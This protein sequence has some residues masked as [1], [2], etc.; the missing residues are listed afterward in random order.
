MPSGYFNPPCFLWVVIA[1]CF[2]ALV[3]AG[4]Q[5]PLA[6]LGTCTSAEDCSLNGDCES[7]VC[8][9]DNFWSGS[10]ACDVL[11]LLP[12][13]H[14]EGYRNSSGVSSWGGMSIKNPRTG[15]WE[16]FAAEMVNHCPLAA[17]KDNSRI[18]RGVSLRGPAGP[19]VIEQEVSAPFSHNPKILRATDGTY[20]LFS[21]GSGL[22]TTAPQTCPAAAD[23]NASQGAARLLSARGGQVPY[24]G[25]CGDGCGPA[26]LNG[27]CGLS[28]GTAPALEGPWT[29]A[30]INV[31]NQSASALLDC[32]HTNPSPWI[33]PNGS[34]VMAI[35]AGYCHGQLETIGLL[36]APSYA[37]PW[38]WYETDPVLHNADG[39]VHHCEDPFL[40]VTQRGFHLMVHNQQGPN[41]AL[42]A[43]S[44]DGHA[45]VLHN[46]AGNPGPY[47]GRVE[48]DDGTVSEHDVE[49]PQFVFD[50]VTGVPLYLT[51]GAEAEPASFT[52]F[53]PLRQTPPPPPPP[54]VSIRSAS[55]GCLAP[56]GSFPCWTAPA[57]FSL[58]PLV[59]RN[60]SGAA[61]AQWRVWP[62]GSPGGQR[63]EDPQGR[64]L[65]TDCD[66]CKVGAGV[67]LI[68]SGASPYALAGSQ[69]V[70]CG[71]GAQALCLS[72]AAAAAQP[73]HPCSPPCSGG[74]EPWSASQVHLEACSDPSTVG[75]QVAY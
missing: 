4:K 17:W 65:N 43:H 36:S 67:K 62:A 41:V 16:L 28:L 13:N 69:I 30:A 74:T 64:P 63:I 3:S 51:N 35:N 24:P 54:L 12:A 5:W 50:P 15:Q 33:F 11:S 72:G 2:A 18:I 6:P 49:R 46:D 8:V 70:A 61:A 60:C 52:L 38:S 23:K 44:L 39:S 14:S 37:G 31:T 66:A 7:G 57:G 20:L 22:W 56:A 29:F 19:F 34:I 21:I 42:Y 59:V 32:A 53:R 68:S 58:C 25:P 26:P 75:W 45:W 73:P 71:S 10:A 48:W 40:W 27:G 9:C 55:G 47:S 1:A